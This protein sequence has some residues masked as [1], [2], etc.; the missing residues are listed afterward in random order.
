MNN[1]DYKYLT[2][3]KWFILE[4]FPFIEAD[5]DA[6][7]NWQLFCKLGKEMNKIID[8]TN[9]TGEQVENLTNAFN[10]LKSYFE[11]LDVQEEINNKLDEMAEEG[12]LQEIITSYLQIAGVLAFNTVLDLKNTENLINGSFVRT[13]GFNEINDG[14]G[15]FYKII[16][17][18][19]PNE[20]NLIACQNNLLAQIIVNPNEIYPEKFGAVGDGITDDTE[21]IQFC[22]DNYD[23]VKFYNKTYLAKGLFIYSNKTLIGEETTIKGDNS[24]DGLKLYNNTNTAITNVHIKGIKLLSY[25]TGLF[26]INVNHSLFEKIIIKSCD[27]D[28]N[29]AGATWTNKFYNCEFKDSRS[30]GFKCGLTV[31]HPIINLEVPRKYCY[32]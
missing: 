20:K 18:G 7:T 23:I 17:E 6:L 3:F 15:A 27:L 10:E 21:I 30:D 13:L 25:N 5:F 11:N 24:T 14:G 4:N 32:I 2:P 9:L 19:T 8:S 31:T 16:N 12:T 29:F 28:A 22:I 26:G 1:Y